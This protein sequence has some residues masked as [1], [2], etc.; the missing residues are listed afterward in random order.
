MEPPISLQAHRSTHNSS[1]LPSY[2]IVDLALK[3]TN[4]DNARGQHREHQS[5]CGPGSPP[6][7]VSGSMPGANR[8]MLKK[9]HVR[10]HSESVAKST[11]ATPYSLRERPVTSPAA[12][13]CPIDSDNS[14]QP[15]AAARQKATR[16]FPASHSNA[17]YLVKGQGPPPAMLT[18]RFPNQAIENPTK[19]WVVNQSSL[20]ATS[21]IDEKRVPAEPAAEPSKPITPLIPPIRGFKTSR[22]SSVDNTASPRVME[23]ETLTLDGYTRQRAS[24][25]E[26]EEQSSDDSDLF[27]KLARE[28]PSGNIRGPIRRVRWRIPSFSSDF[29][30]RAIRIPVA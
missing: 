27:L 8:G 1:K 11:P 12:G 16:S 10:N 24:R 7:T 5:V 21:P 13:S 28:E 19:D 30:L 22:K 14:S 25:R 3:P 15:L 26:Q 23:D 29:A 17:G 9:D 18:Q 2:R 6:S 4:D 20:T